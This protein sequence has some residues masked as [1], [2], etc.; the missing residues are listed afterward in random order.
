MVIAADHRKNGPVN[1]LVLM[2]NAGGGG[3]GAS[4]AGGGT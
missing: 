3:T 2:A 4:R 1:R